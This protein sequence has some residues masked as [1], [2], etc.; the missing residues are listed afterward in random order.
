MYPAQ[1][2]DF[3]CTKC[4]GET[5]FLLDRCFIIAES[6]FITGTSP[7]TTKTAEILT[8]VGHV[9]VLVSDIGDNISRPAFPHLI[10]S[11]CNPENIPVPSIQEQGCVWLRKTMPP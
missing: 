9:Q 8:Y 1:Q 3:G 5:G 7:K 2:T 11:R 6:S 4:K 10:C